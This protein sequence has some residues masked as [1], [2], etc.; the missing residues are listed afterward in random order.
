MAGADPDTGWV[1]RFRQ[2]VRGALHEAIEVHR[3]LWA[4]STLHVLALGIPLGLFVGRSAGQALYNVAL[5]AG[6]NSAQSLPVILSSLPVF[7]GGAIVRITLVILYI[8]SV[9]PRGYVGAVICGLASSLLYSLTYW[10]ILRAPR[11]FLAALAVLK[12]PAQVAATAL[13]LLESAPLLASVPAAALALLKSA[14]AAAVVFLKSAPDT[15]ID[16]LKSAPATTL[17]VLEYAPAQ[18]AAVTAIDTVVSGGHF[19]HF[20]LHALFLLVGS[21]SPHVLSLYIAGATAGTVYGLAGLRWRRIQEEEQR[22][23]AEYERTTAESAR[24]RALPL[25]DQ[26]R[27]IVQEK[28]TDKLPVAID[29]PRLALKM[30]ITGVNGQVLVPRV[31]DNGHS[32]ENQMRDLLLH[33]GA[34]TGANDVV[35][36]VQNRFAVRTCLFA[37]WTDTKETGVLCLLQYRFEEP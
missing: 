13:A 5:P 10:M 4:A 29:F 30:E 9:Q 33:L 35:Q 20:V 14:P 11:E 23:R 36:C 37:Y 17:S 3:K 28:S 24:R 16:L 27:L 8:Y 22:V 32:V 25:V 6:E 19:P 31:R 26:L 2:K 18:V 21:S 12:S 34:C 15:A 1:Q 7:S